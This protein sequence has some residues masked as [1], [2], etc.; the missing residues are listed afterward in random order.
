MAASASVIQSV[1]LHYFGGGSDKQYH[2]YLCDHGGS[3]YT[4]HGE[5]GRTG[6]ISQR[7]IKGSFRSRFS[8][9]EAYSKLESEKRGK[10]YDLMHTTRPPAQIPTPTVAATPP[11]PPPPPK[12]HDQ[13]LVALDARL[14]AYMLSANEEELS[15]G[16]TAIARLSHEVGVRPST[17]LEALPSYGPLVAIL[18]SFAFMSEDYIDDAVR[19]GSEL[20]GTSADLEQAGRAVDLLSPELAE[21]MNEMLAEHPQREGLPGLMLHLF[22]KGRASWF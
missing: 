16:R 7:A 17:D 20:V 10:G 8:A 5:Y 1:S 6:S 3:V 19:L 9:Q 2:I 22:D 13:V 12:V 4:V 18:G 11:P 15:A 14:A 21:V